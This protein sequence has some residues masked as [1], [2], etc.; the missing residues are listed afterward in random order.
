M[1]RIMAGLLCLI[2]TISAAVSITGCSDNKKTNVTDFV[3]AKQMQD[4]TILHCFCWDFNTI[5]NSME[6]IACAG[7]SAIQTSPINECLVGEDGGMQLYG[8]GKWYYHYQPTDWTI[9][10]YQLGT[11]DEFKAMCDKAEQYGIKVIVDVVPNH[12]TPETSKINQNFIDAVGGMDKMYHAGNAYD[13]TNYGDRLECTTY[14]MGG[15][16]DVN[17]ENPKFQDYFFKYINDCIACGADGFRY[18]TA[19]H[20]GLPDDPKENDGYEN[21]FW[22][23]AINDVDNAKNLFI[24]GEVLQGSNERIDDYIKMIGHATASSYGSVLRSAIT[25]FDLTAG[26]LQK[27]YVG[28]GLEKDVVTWVESHD[29][30]I[31]DGSYLEL[32]DSTIKLAWAIIAARKD[33]TPLFFDRPYGGNASDCWGTMN[34]IGVSGSYLYKDPAVVAVN[35]FRTAMEGEDDAF[36]NPLDDKN[37]LCIERADK[38]LVIINREAGTK[39]DFDTNLKNGKYT[40]RVDGKTQYVVKGGKITCETPLGDNQVVVL[41]NEN[42]IDYAK[43]ATVKINDDVNLNFEGES[44]DV[45]LLCENTSNATYQLDD[46]KE[47][48]YKSG[49]KLTVKG[50]KQLTNLTLRASNEQGVKTYMKYVFTQEIDYPVTYGDSVYFS[51]PDNWGDTI[52]AHITDTETNYDQTVTMTKDSI[53]Y[54]YDIESPMLSPVI[55]FSDGKNTYPKDGTLK[56]EP[57]KVYYPE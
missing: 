28:E 48:P 13:M 29:N 45:T 1:K 6:D 30:Y 11:R 57:E 8:N 52:T 4:G 40:D 22:P 31:N 3:T 27:L 12:T 49:E 7:Y 53:N 56:L 26:P 25:R 16:P 20:I 5:A 34:R 17:T 37:T 18:D 43:P 55:T 38:G 41:Y 2:I 32:D 44:V 36:V 10:N 50:G 54:V 14:K 42:Y 33:G 51:K 39:V 23:K 15:L 47:T 19:K 35:R 24:Y 21:N 46:G 9:G